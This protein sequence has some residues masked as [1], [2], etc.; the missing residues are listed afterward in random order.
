M[1]R[2]SS[3]VNWKKIILLVALVMLAV[4]FFGIGWFFFR[5]VLLDFSET[6]GI[7]LDEQQQPI[8][9]AV[10]YVGYT[11][12]RSNPVDSAQVEVL[13]QSQAVTDSNGRFSLGAY[14]EGVRFDGSFF[15][16]TKRFKVQTDAWHCVKIQNNDPNAFRIRRNSGIE[17]WDCLRSEPT[18]YDMFHESVGVA[19]APKDYAEEIVLALTDSVQ[20]EQMDARFK[21]KIPAEWKKVGLMEF[22][23]SI[24]YH[25]SWTVSEGSGGDEKLILK[26]EKDAVVATVRCPIPEIDFDASEFEMISQTYLKHG[27]LHGKT[28]W[29]NKKKIDEDSENTNLLFVH[30]DSFDQRSYGGNGRYSCMVSMADR[31][32]LEEMYEWIEW[33]H[34]DSGDH[35]PPNATITGRV[36]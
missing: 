30:I 19:A 3:P 33:A 25:P 35:V 27:F 34:S 36:D 1:F 20:K 16:C 6:T 8:A 7:L 14:S 26:N 5:P 32:M 2:Y 28:M 31:E 23:E 24:P 13:H 22:Y 18:T 12:M 9:G 17:T 4:T 21:E 10:V 29:L 15:D 11:C